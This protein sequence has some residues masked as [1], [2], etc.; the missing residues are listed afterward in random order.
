M[1]VGARLHGG[2]VPGEHLALYVHTHVREDTL[3]LYG[4][5]TPED[6]ARYDVRYD[7]PARILDGRPL[8]AGGEHPRQRRRQLRYLPGADDHF[9]LE[10]NTVVYNGELHTQC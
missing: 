2:L 1:H 6:F 4:V 3:A 9:P 10:R 8:E 5:A 7:E